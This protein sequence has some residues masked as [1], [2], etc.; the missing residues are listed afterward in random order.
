MVP[1][2]EKRLG[3][4]ISVATEKFFPQLKV[5]AKFLLESSLSLKDQAQEIGANY[6]STGYR[7]FAIGTRIC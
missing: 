5:F 4:S 1:K 7:Y 3:G 2:I 6:L